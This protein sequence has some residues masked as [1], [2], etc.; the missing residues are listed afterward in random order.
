MI[1]QSPKTFHEVIDLQQAQIKGQN[2][3]TL[4]IELEVLLGG[5]YPPSFFSLNRALFGAMH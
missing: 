3:G 4:K 2:T 1:S 5:T